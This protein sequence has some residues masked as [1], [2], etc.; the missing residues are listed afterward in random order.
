MTPVSSD[1]QEWVR[2]TKKMRYPAFFYSKYLQKQNFI[3][4]CTRKRKQCNNAEVAQLGEL[5]LPRLGSR[6]RVPS[7]A[8]LLR[9]RD[10][11]MV[12][13]VDTKDLKS[14]GHCGCAGSSPASSTQV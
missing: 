4:L 7:S 14:F 5:T 11:R 3:Y 8:H 13:S 10:A 12:E 2:E 9:E 6:V 1:R